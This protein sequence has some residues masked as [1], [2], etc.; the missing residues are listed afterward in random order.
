MMKLKKIKTTRNYTRNKTAATQIIETLNKA[1]YE[2]YLVGGCVRDMLLNKK[3]SDFDI[4]TSALPEQ[5]EKLFPKTIPV[6]KSFGVVI[7]QQHGVAIE[8]ATFR[9]DVAYSDGRRP[10]QVRFSSAKED[11]LRRDFTINGL[12]YDSKQKKVVDWVKGKKDLE[13]QIIRTIG[14]P[15][16]R[17]EEDKLRML[18][19]I[20]FSANL[21]FKIESK[22]FQTIC[23]MKQ[24]IVSVSME[25]VRDELR[26]IFTGNNPPAGLQLLIESGLLECLYP[27]IA[28]LRRYHLR[29]TDDEQINGLEVLINLFKFLKKSSSLIYFAALIRHLLL[30]ENKPLPIY[31][32]EDW[33]SSLSAKSRSVTSIE[34]LCEQLRLSNEEKKEITRMIRNAELFYRG[35]KL[36]MSESKRLLRQQ[37]IENDLSLFANEEKLLFKSQK[38]TKYFKQ[39]QIAWTTKDLYPKQFLSGNDLMDMGIKAGPKLGHTLFEIETLQLENILHTKKEITAWVL[40]NK[41]ITQ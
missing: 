5:V 8:V 12:Y 26:K 27:S 19:A 25:R 22:T 36:S 18:R 10:D 1:G 40:K 28:N 32:I 34:N 2:A 9:E 13:A 31:S 14:D 6:G 4:S 29:T 20:R 3:P 15:S 38:R 41:P 39:K 17:F 24:D 35:A 21:N 37:G 7:V 16:K 30:D 23:R 33:V 11:A